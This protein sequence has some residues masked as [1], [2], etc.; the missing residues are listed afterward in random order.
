MYIIKSSPKVKVWHFSFVSPG[1]MVST[2][3]DRSKEGEWGEKE[4]K[5]NKKSSSLL[6]NRPGRGR[7]LIEKLICMN[8]ECKSR[9]WEICGVSGFKQM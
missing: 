7:K 6:M 4:Q 5:K 3:R 8:A 2:Q 1:G 9:M